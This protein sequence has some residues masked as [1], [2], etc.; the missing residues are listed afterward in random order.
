MK[1]AAWTLVLVS[2]LT[3]TALAQ[4]PSVG[5]LLNNYSFTLPGL[6]NYGIAQGSIFDI[7]GTNLAST[8]TGLQNPPLQTTLEGTSISVTVNGTTT[9]PLIYFVSAGQIA[10]I[11]PSATPVGTGTITVTTAA[12]TSAPF[13][14]Q[15]VESAFGLL[16]KNN[17]T[18][19]VAGFDANNS[20]KLMD[21]SQAANPGDILELWGTGLGPVAGDATGVAVSTPIEVDIAGVQAQVLYHGRSGYAGLDQINVKVPTGLAGCNLSVVVISNGIPSNYGTLPVAASGRACSDPGSGITS[22]LLNTIKSKGSFS[23]GYVGITKTTTPGTTIGGITIGGGTKDAGFASFTKITAA[24]F[25]SAGYYGGTSIGSCTI[26]TFNGQ[27][28][29][30]GITGTSLNAGPNVNITGPNGTIAM[31]FTTTAGFGSYFTGA[32]QAS[33][34]PAAGG[35]FTFDNGSGGPDVGSFSAQL[36]V[37]QPLVWSNMSALTT[38][39]RSAGATVTWTGGDPST[40]VTITGTS[41]STPDQGTTF[42]GGFFTCLAPTAPGSFTVPAPV[43]MSLP[44]STT[45]S[46][47]SFSTLSVGNSTKPTFFSASGLDLGSVSATVSS[48]ENVT[49]Q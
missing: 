5:G 47:I 48:S 3:G 12:G 17:G 29:P 2:L 37:A 14:I 39:T 1:S 27:A 6:P 23:A 7:F 30:S 25:T 36:V 46:G 21:Y 15:V 38:I 8:T 33:F 45:I 42:L 16:T 18:G 35:T 22:D 19:P 32:N 44:A 24:Q 41:L 26:L 49:Y 10:A 40:F 11:L 34:I 9:Q 13:N 20:Y 43:L 4:T 31:P 28:P